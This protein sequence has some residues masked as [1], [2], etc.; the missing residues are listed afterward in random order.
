MRLK[1]TYSA[2]KPLKDLIYCK[3]KFSIHTF[4]FS[5]RISNK[6]SMTIARKA[7][8][9]ERGISTYVYSVHGEYVIL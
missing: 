5:E 9:K 7:M 3:H 1:W 2:I 8:Q 4:R 6:S